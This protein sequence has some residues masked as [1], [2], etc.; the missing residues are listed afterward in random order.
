MTCKVA[1]IVISGA[2]AVKKQTLDICVCNY[3]KK[4]WEAIFCHLNSIQLWELKAK[5]GD[6]GVL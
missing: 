1:L 6:L 2:F 3:I 4:N 5:E